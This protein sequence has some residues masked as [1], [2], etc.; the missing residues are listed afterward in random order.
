MI[1]QKVSEYSIILGMKQ[2]VE[3]NNV[4]DRHFRNS[5]VNPSTTL[6]NV[7]KMHLHVSYQQLSQSS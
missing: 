6:E 3:N 4:W 1:S 5:I 2:W 7:R